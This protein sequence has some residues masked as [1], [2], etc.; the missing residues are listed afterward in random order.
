VQLE[1]PWH[2]NQTDISEFIKDL[3]CTEGDRS[4]HW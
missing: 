2:P 4:P 3:R 1:H